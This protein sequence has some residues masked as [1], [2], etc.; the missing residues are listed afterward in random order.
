MSQGKFDDHFAARIRSV[1]AS[2]I[3]EICRLAGMKDFISLAG[4]WPNPDTFPYDFTRKA[5]A[6]LMRA[7]T[8][9]ALQYGMSEGLLPLRQWFQGWLKEREGIEAGIDE[10]IITAG[11][12]NAMDLTCR[13]LVDEGDVCLVDLPTYIGGSGSI[14]FYGGELV[15]GPTDNHGTCVDAMENILAG[16]RREGRKVKLF[17]LLSLNHNPLGV[18]MSES[19]KRK[20]M[21][22]ADE[23]D[24]LLMEDNPYGDLFYRG[25]RRLPVKAQ[26]EHGRIV[27]IKSFS[28]IFSPGI[29]MAVVVGH[30]DI[31]G[32]MTIARQFVDCCPSNLSQYLLYEFCSSGMIEKHIRKIRRFYA[33]RR[34][35][36]LGLIEKYFP[37]EVRTTNPSG[38]LF[39]FVYLPEKINA[40]DVLQEVMALNVVF[41]TGSQFYV[42]GSGTNTFRMS[43]A[44]VREDQM[45]EA[46][47]KIGKVL[48]EK[49]Q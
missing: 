17:Y 46:I 18:T 20:L 15:G 43:F 21:R 23:Y 48:H 26:D 2:T 35:Q 5:I 8:G 29:R 36:M 42:D 1:N 3:R 12:Q 11:S 31:I 28:K 34:E 37:R 19:R 49:L 47:S 9:D 40:A 32:R 30:R 22:L 33:A 6:K 27:Y 16:L 44:Q 25:K 10:I 24:F 45:E 41:V 4:G 13:V 7:R 38:G 14:Q 39:V